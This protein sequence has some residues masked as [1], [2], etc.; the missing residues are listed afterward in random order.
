MEYT[1]LLPHT[2]RLR[3][4]PNLEK[5][6]HDDYYHKSLFITR[7]AL[8]LGLSL[9][10]IFGILDEWVAPISF[11]QIW[12]LRYAIM[13]PVII[14]TLLLTWS[15][16]FSRFMQPLLSLTV[17]ITGLGMAAMSG[18]ARPQEP[19]FSGYYVGLIL[20]IMW[21]Y[22]FIR[23]RFW[24]ALASSLII[25]IGYEVVAI[26]FQGLLA[27]PMGWLTFVNNNFFLV[28]A[29]V[30]GGTAAYYLEL[31][32]RRDFAQRQ[33]I[34]LEKTKSASLLQNEAEMALRA[35]EARFRSLVEISTEG[36]AIYNQQAI[37]QYVSPAFEQLVGY[38]RVELLGQPWIPLVHSQDLPYLMERFQELLQGPGRRA[39]SELRLIRQDGA[40][41]YVEGVAQSLPDGN[42]VAFLHDITERKQAEDELRCLNEELEDRV[43]ERTAQLE[44][45]F[46]ERTRLAQ[47]LEATSDLV[48]FATLDGRPLY[49]NRAGRRMVGFPDDLDV[50][51][52]TFADFYPPDTLELFATVGVPTALRE[53]TWSAEVNLKHWGDDRLVPVSMVGIIHYAPDGTPTHL[54]AIIRDISER[55]QAEAELQN[56]LAESRRLATIIEAMPDY[57]GI[58]DLQGWSLYVNKAGRQL[59]GKPEKDQTPWNVANCY[60]S[61][62]ATRLQ[63]MF[64]AMQAGEAWAGEIALQHADGQ[65]IPVEQT[66]FPLHDS[67]GAIESYA[68]VIRDITERKR[69]QLDLEKARDNAEAASRAKSTFLANMSHEL[70]TPLTAIIGYT[71]ILQDDASDY[72]YTELLPKLERIH[73]SGTHLLSLI[74]D[75]LDFSKIEAGK[76]ELYLETF[77]LSELIDNLMVT[78]QPLVQKRGNTLQVNYAKDLGSIHADQTKIRQIVLNLL[79]NAAKFTENGEITLTIERIP[80]N[81]RGAEEQKSEGEYTTPAP[82]LPVPSAEII[83]KVADTGI[84]MSAE[85]QARLFEAFNQADPSTTRQY[86]GTGLG[87]AITRRLCQLMGGDI[88]VESKIGQGSIFTVHLPA[89]VN[90]GNVERSSSADS[91]EQMTQGKNGF[92]PSPIANLTLPQGIQSPDGHDRP[93][94]LVIDDDLSVRELLTNY[95]VKEGFQVKTAVTA[96]EGL[97]LAKVERPDVITLDVL[98]PDRCIDGWGALAAFK[99]DTSLADIPVIMVTIVDDKNRGFAL[100]ASDY[101]AKPIDREHLITILNK[102]RLQSKH[103]PK[104]AFESEQALSQILVVEDDPAIREMLRYTL[105]PEGLTVIEAGNGR[106]ALEQMATNHPE[107]I[108]LDLM[109]PEMDGFEFILKLRQNPAW[110][111]IPVVVITAL[112]LTSDDCLRLN[113]YIQQV[114]HKV[115]AEADQDSF[116]QEVRNL[117][118][119]CIHS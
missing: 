39:A 109:M 90:I 27:S 73:I 30:V 12:F 29:N 106:V 36:I 63:G 57:V 80:I 8:M 50:N 38:T 13:C 41:R 112:N 108:L 56:A 2:N 86:G 69:T 48:A 71:E 99:A 114:V 60:P 72:G 84:G 58:A 74:N 96:E 7:V 5:Q 75:I 117:V 116:L 28:A 111:N 66:I 83:F 64:E 55:K 31:Y 43:I 21:A 101:L 78:A 24:Y 49:I 110:Q 65:V 100:G 59:V 10:A 14:L 91:G 42:I 23:L 20:V 62:E 89:K 54:S 115:T 53:G 33:A 118:H 94:V 113:G 3:F 52:V 16:F 40:I 68:A 37:F 119:A 44:A 88:I 107:L 6:F 103:N 19:G 82:L 45:A 47:I 25:V 35:S 22:T 77:S 102:Y 81:S 1:A 87:L 97:H 76:M 18:I 15:P 98:M 93:M 32:T 51:T 70:R 9:I 4:P 92:T 17:L 105:E 34:E 61:T 46:A 104:E 26:V 95:L 67:S 79:S 11:H 85:Q